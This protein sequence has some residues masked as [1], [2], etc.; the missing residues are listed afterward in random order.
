MNKQ[1]IQ[2]KSTEFQPKNEYVLVK[3]KELEQEEKSESGIVL[4]L[5]S[6]KS[7]LIRPTLGKVISVGADIDDV[8]EGMYIIWP[9][10]DGLD[11]EFDDGDYMLIRY[12]SI[13]GMKKQ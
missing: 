12:K 1:R 7:S 2:F 9:E 10:T 4:S 8:K 11:L 3:P 6:Q 13:V 5:N